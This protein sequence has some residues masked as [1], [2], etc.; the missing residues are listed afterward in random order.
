MGKTFDGNLQVPVILGE[1]RGTLT[2]L[3]TVHMLIALVN[4]GPPGALRNQLSLG[5][6]VPATVAVMNCLEDRYVD[7]LGV[8]LFQDQYLCTRGNI[9]HN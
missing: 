2:S 1:I 7:E 3:T 5:F 6:T 4:A 8:E 9:H